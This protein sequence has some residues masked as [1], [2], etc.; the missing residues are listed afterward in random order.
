MARLGEMHTPEG[1]NNPEGNPDKT[2]CKV[3]NEREQRG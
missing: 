3:Q 2:D 1:K